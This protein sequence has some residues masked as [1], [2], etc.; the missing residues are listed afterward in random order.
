MNFIHKT[1]K[2]LQKN[3]YFVFFLF[4]P[5]IR[6]NGKNIIF[7]DKKINKSNFYKNKKLSKID[8]IDV[9]K[10]L[11]SK[12]EPY[13]TKNS[14][15]YFIGYNDDGVIRPLCI[16]LPQV[17]GYVN[18]DP[19]SSDKY[20]NEPKMDLVMNLKMNVITNLLKFKILF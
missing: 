17:I 4:S 7:S 8:K 15:K 5:S 11:V 9:D 19:S 13:G 16:K 20:D 1:P 6:M 18:L 12:K 3:F 14:I 10:I 2:L